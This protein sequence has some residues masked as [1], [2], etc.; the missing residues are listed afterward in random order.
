MSNIILD[1]SDYYEDKYEYSREGQ[2]GNIEEKMYNNP[3]DINNFFKKRGYCPFCGKE[4]P[5]VYNHTKHD[6]IGIELWAFYDVWECDN[7]GWWEYLYRFSEERDYDTRV[8]T[9]NWD[10]FRHGII[11]KFNVSDKQ[12]PINTLMN[13]LLKKQDI[14]YDIDPYKL[15]DIAQI[16]FSSYYDCEVKHVGKTGDG[17]KDLIIVQ[18]DDPILVQIKRRTNREHVELVKGI[19]EFVGTMYIE[20]ANKGVYLSTAKKFS[21]GSQET[22]EQLV[23]NRK[24]DSFELINYERFCD[25]LGVVKKD[26]FKPWAKFVQEK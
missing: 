8:S 4:I 1:Y 10:I 15:E 23:N 2:E 20:G 19:R 14:L 11:K 5:K 21:K 24:F 3:N 7:C 25:M 9:N 22:A 13:E 6:T 18:S 16:V 26:S 12:I 17:G